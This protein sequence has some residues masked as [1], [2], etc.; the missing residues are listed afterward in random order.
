MGSTVERSLAL[1]VQKAAY[2]VTARPATLVMQPGDQRLVMLDVK[3]LFGWTGPVTLTVDA[4]TVPAETT[5][6]FLAGGV[7]SNQMTVTPPQNATLQIAATTTPS[8]RGRLRL[9][10]DGGKRRPATGGRGEAEQQ[11]LPDPLP[12]ILSGWTKPVH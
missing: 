1:T 3:G 12:M 9:A 10:R 5:V 4:T 6:G 8:W 11:R 2:E 7:L